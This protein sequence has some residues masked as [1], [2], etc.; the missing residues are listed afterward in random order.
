MGVGSGDGVGT[1]VGASV[2][3]AVAVSVAVAWIPLLVEQPRKDINRIN[4]VSS[5]NPLFI[6]HLPP[7]YDC[8]YIGAIID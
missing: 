1:G 4:D 5:T 3:T 6:N 8:T 7:I 2:T